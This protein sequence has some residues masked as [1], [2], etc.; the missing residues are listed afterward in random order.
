MPSNHYTIIIIYTRFSAPSKD[1]ANN[2]HCNPGHGAP[3]RRA[4][5]YDVRALHKS[6][7]SLPE[8]EETFGFFKEF[9]EFFELSPQ[10]TEGVFTHRCCANFKTPPV[11]FAATLL[12]EEGK[13][14]P[15]ICTNPKAPSPRELSRSD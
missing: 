15:E 8:G 4:L 11:S 13:P 14:M 7:G 5:Q 2:N 9:F 6:K 1:C 3:S 12:G 10:V